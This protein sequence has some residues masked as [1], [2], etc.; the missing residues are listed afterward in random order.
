MPPLTRRVL[1]GSTALV[2]LVQPLI[3]PVQAFAA[4]R[5]GERLYRRGRFKR[6]RGRRFRLSDGAV[7]YRAKLVK[8]RNLPDGTAGDQE[9]FSLLFRTSRRLPADGGTYIL[10]RAG[11]APTALFVVPL[12]ASGR[13][14][15]AVINSAPRRRRRR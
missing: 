10:Q 9:Q 7:T 14:C 1:L 3:D 2:A 11:F 8:V 13:L 12:G 4:G 15:E 5:T 6:R